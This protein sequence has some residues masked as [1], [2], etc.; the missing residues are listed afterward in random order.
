[1]SV[2][3]PI[4]FL[5]YNNDLPDG[6]TSMYKI[7]ADGTSLFSKVVDKNNSNP[8]HNS[9]LTKI[10][11]WAFQW[12]TSFNPDPNKQAIE[13]IRSYSKLQKTIRLYNL[14]IQTYR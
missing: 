11:R 4:L 7:F 12:K 9:D 1:M 14:T 8:Q 2:L 10:S 3:R 6:L 5:I 13:I